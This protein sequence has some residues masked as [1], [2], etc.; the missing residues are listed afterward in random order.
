MK[1]TPLAAAPPAGPPFFIG[2]DLALD[3]LNSTLGEAPQQ[4]E[5]LQDDLQVL[6]WLAQAGLPAVPSKKPPAPGVRGPLHRTAIELR[7]HARELVEQR[8]AGEIGEP[9]LLNTLLARASSHTELVWLGT[10][11]ALVQRE[12]AER[13]ED[14]LLPVAVAIAELLAEGDFRLVRQCESPDCTLW[15]YDRTK[16]HQ[17]RWCSMAVCGNRMKVAAF[18]ARQKAE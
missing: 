18:R 1:S 3:F 2:G 8:V 13:P 16:S 12:R 4:I 11:P 5:G 17:R 10:V 9:T 14:L 15:F 6:Q 7:A